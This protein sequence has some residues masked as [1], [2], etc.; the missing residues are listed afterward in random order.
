MSE[1][2]QLSAI[3]SPRRDSRRQI[4]EQTLLRQ[5][6][7]RLQQAQRIG[8]LGWWEW[9]IKNNR[10]AWSD[11][12]FRIFGV[13]P[14]SIEPAYDTFLH[15]LH[16][17][18]RACVEHAFR[19]AL[20]KT[21]AY[22]VDCRI[23]QP[24]GQ[25]RYVRCRGNVIRN[26]A[27]TP[28]RMI[29]TVLDITELKRAED[30]AAELL[31]LAQEITGTLDRCDLCNRVQMRAALLLQCDR[32]L[33][34][35]RDSRTEVFRLIGHYGFPKAHVS[36]AEAITFPAGALAA[37]GARLTRGEPVSVMLDDRSQVSEELAELGA[38]FGVSAL[39]AVP[40]RMWGM[41]RGLLAVCRTIGAQPFGP[42]ERDLLSG[43]AGQLAVA[44][45]AI[46]RYEAQQEEVGVADALARVG[47][48]LLLSLDS[49]VLLD[50]L[51][52]LT[53]EVLQCDYCDTV[54]WQADE[55]VYSAAATYGHPPH[56]SEILGF[57]KIADA[58]TYH[59]RGQLEG[60]EVLQRLAA[61][62]PAPLAAQFARHGVGRVLFVPLRRGGRYI[63][64][65]DAGFYGREEPFTPAQERI[66]K[67]IGQLASM[68]LGHTQ[69]VAELARA[70]RVKSE[71]VATMSHELRTPLNI[72]IGYNDLLIEE[73][74][75][76]L[77]PEQRDTLQRV[78]RSAAQLLELINATLDMSRLDVGQSLLDVQDVD[79][80]ELLTQ[81]RA[82]VI[83]LHDKLVIAA[84]WNAAGAFR[85][86]TD[87]AKLKLLLK[88]LL[89]NAV[90]F[91]PKGRITISARK[92]GHGVEISVADTGIGIAPDVLPVI[93]E[94]FRQGD[95]S[96]TRRFG[97]VG[98]GLYIVRRL[99]DL[100]GGTITV[101]SAVGRGSTFRVWLPLTHA[102][103]R[104]AG[105][106][107]PPGAETAVCMFPS[108]QATS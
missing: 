99:L 93:F 50:R 26:G 71:F 53:T 52:Q 42:E 68:A 74:F 17:D 40:L 81:V 36:R 35:Y 72:I 24:Q 6:Q 32:V 60:V 94:P 88:N 28:V 19:E 54:L 16:P 104:A 75:G 11:E 51:C 58:E 90:K 107:S 61:E 76:P 15:A 23:V 89:A 100:L 79:L 92:R 98:L 3:S 66:A 83:G 47:R 33:T 39:L 7:Q 84:R 86:R 8:H 70:N 34:F 97:G 73:V 56:V 21:D 38:R 27:R 48:E 63:G 82:K 45:E 14:H 12:Q 22:D 95:S 69:T 106:A 2:G 85:L 59:L 1:A 96:T 30:T 91:T 67:G 9:D 80:A 29:G 4:D 55:H 77:A 102:S 31:R 101:K 87:R 41:Y 103:G 49:S 37:F 5:T 18:D 10:E 43:I 64:F 62:V 65:L 20:G 13:V 44:M 25:I 108:N 78:H 46:E 105:E 57:L